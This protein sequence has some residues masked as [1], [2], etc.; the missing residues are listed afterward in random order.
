MHLLSMNIKMKFN[1]YKLHI[2]LKNMLTNRNAC[3]IIILELIKSYFY[4]KYIRIVEIGFSNDYIS[5]KMAK[6]TYI[7]C[8]YLY[9]I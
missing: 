2:F 4:S 8:Y 1:F 3:A 9:K 6:S 7:G 5:F